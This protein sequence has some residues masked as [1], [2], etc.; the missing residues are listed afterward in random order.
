MNSQ[1]KEKCPFR[2]GDLVVYRPSE[3]GQVVDI[4]APPSERLTHNQTYR[5]KHI[6]DELYV[7]VE[8]YKHPGG[9]IYWTE[10]EP[11]R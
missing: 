6:Q 11:S 3:R 5:I 1:Q 7:I 9:G 10:F 8:G 2:I 4:M